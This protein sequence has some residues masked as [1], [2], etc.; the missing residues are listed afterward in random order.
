MAQK[1]EMKDYQT[2]GWGHVPFSGHEWP[3]QSG[4]HSHC[5]HLHKTCALSPLPSVT[6]TGG[7]AFLFTRQ[8]YL[9]CKQN[10]CG[11]G[12]RT[13][14]EEG[15]EKWVGLRK[16]RGDGCDHNIISVYETN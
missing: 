16:G 1:R 3:S 5:D 4:I 10:G 7:A 8:P 9:N 12:M 13:N 15:S 6:N 14:L 11:S 2:I